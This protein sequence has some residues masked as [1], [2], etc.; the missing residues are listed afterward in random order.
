MSLAQSPLGG[1]GGGS[2]SPQARGEGATSE[3]PLIIVGL[4]GRATETQQSTLE[5]WL[6]CGV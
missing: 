2:G 3:C 4:L 6:Q 1:A 5:G